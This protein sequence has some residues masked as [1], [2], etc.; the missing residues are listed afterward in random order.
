LALLA[1]TWQAGV[2]APLDEPLASFGLPTTI[3]PEGSVGL[4]AAG[5]LTFM[6]ARVRREGSKRCH[7]PQSADGS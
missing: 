4:I 6:R 1:R 7:R 2:G 3:V 5:V